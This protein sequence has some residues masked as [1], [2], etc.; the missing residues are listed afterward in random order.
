MPNNSS[1]TLINQVSIRIDRELEPFAEEIITPQGQIIP[2]TDEYGDWCNK[3]TIENL[4]YTGFNVLWGSRFHE[5]DYVEWIIR[6]WI[7]DK[8]ETNL[9]PKSILSIVQF[10]PKLIITSIAPEEI[11]EEIFK[12]T[13]EG[14]IEGAIREGSSLLWGAQQLYEWCLD[15]DL[16]GFSEYRKFELDSIR[17]KWRTQELSVAMRDSNSGPYTTLEM[18]L[19]E[20]ALK[21]SS[22]VTIE[23]IALFYL[24]RDWGL[25]PIQMSLLHTNDF[26][27]DHLGPYIM[28]PSVKGKKRSRLRR[29]AS[30][31]VKRY[32]TDET[33]AAIQ[34]QIEQSE[35]AVLP[36]ITALQALL[37][38]NLTLGVPLFPNKY[39]SDERLQR[40]C[41]NTKLA[42][43]VLHSGSHKISRIIRDLTHKLRVIPPKRLG[44]KIPDDIMPITAYRFRRT[45]GTSMV[46]S[47]ATPEEVAEALDHVSV[48]SI[49]YYFR[50]SA[51]VHDFV[52]EAHSASPE[53]SAAIAMWEGRLDKQTELRTGELSIS[54]LGK[55]TLG[56]ICPHHPTV[57]CYSCPSFRPNKSADHQGA[58]NSIVEYKNIIATSSTGPV[59]NQLDV[60]IYGAKAV[61]IAINDEKAHE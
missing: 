37:E 36:R 18:S 16:P 51:E 39:C 10:L 43:Y 13:M 56:S 17:P 29:A 30:N 57:T 24:A 41:R 12:W 31:M 23:D 20:T 9:T 25:R 14:A 61:I 26:G 59:V 2:T 1:L 49:K 35:K 60:A 3:L 19:L 28:V 21:T 46:I 4:G 55:C 52:N 50:F 11:E 54:S 27:R 8:L 5:D 15:E 6:S 45:K 53:I 34:N 33:A 58:L 38:E 47:G 44:Q 42:N 40:L 22:N 48:D 32:I 7:A